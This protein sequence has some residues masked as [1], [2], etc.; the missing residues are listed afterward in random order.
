MLGLNRIIAVLKLQQLKEKGWSA[1]WEHI[2]PGYPIAG[3]L[4]SATRYAIE[5]E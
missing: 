1:G 5:S 3:T 2:Y 4:T